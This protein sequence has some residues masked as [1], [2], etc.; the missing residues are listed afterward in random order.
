MISEEQVDTFVA[1]H[2]AMLQFLRVSAQLRLPSLVSSDPYGALAETSQNSFCSDDILA[3]CRGV[4]RP[5]SLHVLI[6]AG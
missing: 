4:M 3:L 1:I 5:W 2:N 6:S